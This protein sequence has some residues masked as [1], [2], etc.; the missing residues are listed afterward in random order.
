MAFSDSSLGYSQEVQMALFDRFADQAV[1]RLVEQFNTPA[2]CSVV[3]RIA[4]DRLLTGIETFG[5]SG[6][7]KHPDGLMLEIIEELADAIVYAV[8]RENARS[9]GAGSHYG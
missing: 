3:R 6:W 1:T 5:D 7:R 8:M 4:K 2:L 9:G